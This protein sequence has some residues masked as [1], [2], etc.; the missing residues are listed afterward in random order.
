MCVKCKESQKKKNVFW[1][2]M[3]VGEENNFLKNV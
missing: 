3:W 2:R 1:F